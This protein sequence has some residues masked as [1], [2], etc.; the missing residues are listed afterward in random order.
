MLTEFDME[1][2]ERFANRLFEL[3]AAREARGK[4]EGK[5]EGKV[6]AL[7]AIFAAR[8]LGVTE[9]QAARIRRTTDLDV[10]DTWVRRAVTAASADDVFTD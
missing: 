10:L 3:A 8:S 2:G 6:E 1:R 7:F 4:A 9:A 5:A